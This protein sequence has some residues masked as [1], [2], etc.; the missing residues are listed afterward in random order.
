MD[1]I[2]FNQLY[3]IAENCADQYYIKVIETFVSILKHQFTD[4]QLLLVNT[5]CS[6]NFWKSTQTAS[7]KFGRYY[8]STKQYQRIFKT[9]SSILMTIKTAY[10]KTL[11]FRRK[12]PQETLKISKL[13]LTSSK[14][15]H[16]LCV[17]T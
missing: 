12:L 5:A 7:P 11:N 10:K 17:C 6:L 2:P 15:I 8:R 3:Y 9:Y 1:N 14:H 4:C 16:H 13:C